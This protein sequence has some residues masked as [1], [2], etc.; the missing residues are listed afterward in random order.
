MPPSFGTEIE[1]V[2]SCKYGIEIGGVLVKKAIDLGRQAIALMQ[3]R[4][5]D[6]RMND[7]VD[8]VTPEIETLVEVGADQLV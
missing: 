7:F 4:P 5:C 1:P 3:P 8:R 2:A 6:E